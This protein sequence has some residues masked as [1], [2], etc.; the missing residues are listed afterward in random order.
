MKSVDL[1]S[2]GIMRLSVCVNFFSP[3]CSCA[4]AR[5]ARWCAPVGALRCAAAR[6]GAHSASS[7]RRTRSTHCPQPGYALRNARQPDHYYYYYKPMTIRTVFKFIRYSLKSSTKRAKRMY[8]YKIDCYFPIAHHCISYMLSL[9]TY[10]MKAYKK[11]HKV[12]LCVFDN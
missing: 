1:P 10:L 7:R 9:S 2:V 5:C 4:N 8:S 12:L 6:T 3:R 11:F